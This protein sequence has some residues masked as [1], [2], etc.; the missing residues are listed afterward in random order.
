MKEYWQKNS[1]ELEEEFPQL[2]VGLSKERVEEIRSRKG[3]NILLEGK[4]KSILL[5]FLSQFCD[6][7]VIILMI[8]AAISMLSGNGESTLVILSPWTV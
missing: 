6:F 2:S 4:R 8:A 3:E 1:Q 7:L 5:V